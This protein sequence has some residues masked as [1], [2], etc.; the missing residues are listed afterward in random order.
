MGEVN[1]TE[2]KACR[3]S[4]G[5]PVLDHVPTIQLVGVTKAFPGVVALD[6][7]H[8]DVFSGEVHA[9]IGLNGA[10]K[11]TLVNVLAGLLEPDAGGI[12]GFG[13]P[14]V[15]RALAGH[16]SL[17]PQE[18][19]VNPTLT[20]GRNVL[21]G[22]ES[23]ATR[24]EL[25][26]SEIGR[27]IAGFQRV[28]LNLDPNTPPSQCSVPELRLAQIA[29]A[30]MAPGKVLLLD[31]PTA[32]LSRTD[33]DRLLAMLSVL[34]TQGEAIVYI[35]H[36]L[37]E[38]LTIADR[39]TVL[40]DGK[41]VKTL[42]GGTVSRKELLGILSSENGPV[43]H[44][45]GT[46]AKADKP[47]TLLT[48]EGLSGPGLR[49]ASIRVRKGEVVALVG[50]PSG[51]Q[52]RFV[53]ILAGAR[54]KSAGTV[55]LGARVVST[56]TVTD[57]LKAGI[58][59]VPADRRDAG[60]VAS[61]TVLENIVLP[62]GSKSHRWNLRQRREEKR[63][64]D[65]YVEDFGMR[66]RSRD[67]AVATLSG[68]NQQKVALVKALEASPRVLLLDEPTQGID[69]TS[70]GKILDDIKWE[71]RISDRVVIS[72]TSELEE[73]VGW[74]DTVYVFRLGEIVAKLQGR[75]VTEEAL[76]ELSVP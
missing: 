57:S 76:I 63:I 33:A 46:F 66:I 54:S 37:S 58:V 6:D 18:I 55:R 56:D 9:V 42:E 52:S 3:R 16:V 34:R 51:G 53:Q 45:H 74:A 7:V 12:R 8:L 35:S 15:G 40:R 68:G 70:K 41:N 73:V 75:K 71:A 67:T 11:S 10:G 69:V 19:L 65:R 25:S 22:T 27:V 60:V 26:R 14:V 1:G 72:A 31:E 44:T 28:G 49:D 36:R 13:S 32:V 62:P 30:L 48:V 38:V 17:V 21:L 59:L 39:I 20:I 5:E 50:V 4:N 2:H 23:F 61:R 43:G 64:V 29:R 24:A 47:E